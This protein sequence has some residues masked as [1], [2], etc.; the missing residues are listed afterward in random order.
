[1]TDNERERMW[2]EFSALVQPGILAA[3]R[4]LASSDE[5]A[6]DILGEIMVCVVRA[7]TQALPGRAPSPESSTS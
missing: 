6:Q 3:I 4:P 7:L 2:A 5:Q 1:M